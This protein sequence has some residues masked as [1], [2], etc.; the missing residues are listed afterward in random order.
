MLQLRVLLM[1]LLLLLLY[2]GTS[3]SSS[4]SRRCNGVP[5]ASQL[6]RWGEHHQHHHDGVLLIENN[7]NTPRT[8]F[9]EKNKIVCVIRNLRG[10][11][12]LELEISWR[13]KS[14]K[15]FCVVVVVVLLRW[16]LILTDVTGDN[17]KS[18]NISKI[19]SI[20]VVMPGGRRGLVAPQNTFLENIIRRCS[21]QR[22]S[23]LSLFS[24]KLLV[25]RFIY[26]NQPQ[27]LN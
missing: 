5:P 15:T 12:K 25:G 4:V 24:I 14:V 26:S 1:L 8:F 2:L 23:P 7:K 19:N 22:K 21:Q 13:N 11:K 17:K 18:T 16:H 10:K 20:K 3:S 27:M 9:E 6:R